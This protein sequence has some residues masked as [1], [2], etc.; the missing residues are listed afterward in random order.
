M[1]EVLQE[2]GIAKF[3][4]KCFIQI[5]ECS[6]WLTLELLITQIQ[7]QIFISFMKTTLNSLEESLQR[8]LWMNSTLNAPL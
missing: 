2:N 6:N 8:P 5:L 7:N 4:S 3:Q 1:L